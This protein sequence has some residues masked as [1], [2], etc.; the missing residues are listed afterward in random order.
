MNKIEVKERMYYFELDRMD[1]INAR[2]TIMFTI[3]AFVS[4]IAFTVIPKLFKIENR[5]IAYIIFFIAFVFTVSYIIGIYFFICSLR[6]RKYAYLPKWDEIESFTF[7]LK[8]FYSKKNYDENEIKI[9]IDKD[10]EDNY[11]ENLV[12]CRDK[13]LELNETRQKNIAWLGIAISVQLIS[14]LIINA[15]FQYLSTIQGGM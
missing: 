4:G 9:L 2:L 3:I 11:V 15:L 5:V 10:I 8:E 14:I 6:G 1:K 13:N 12:K 7:R